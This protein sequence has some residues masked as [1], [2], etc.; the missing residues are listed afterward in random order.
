[1]SKYDPI[2][3]HGN[4]YSQVFFLFLN[5]QFIIFFIIIFFINF[6]ISY[7]HQ[8]FIRMQ[9]TVVTQFW[10][11]LYR[12]VPAYGYSKITDAETMHRILEGRCSAPIGRVFD[13]IS[14][15]HSTCLLIICIR[16]CYCKDLPQEIAK[17]FFFFMKIH[18][19]CL[20]MVVFTKLWYLAI[21]YD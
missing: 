11:F 21:D 7:Y 19:W 8:F 14:R 17:S 10:V 3:L 13:K 15:L 1:M 18:S 4:N 12:E 5:L 2:S 20:K 6:N 16:R 9:H